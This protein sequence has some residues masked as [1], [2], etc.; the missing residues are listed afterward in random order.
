MMNDELSK[1]KAKVQAEETKHN[2]ER[3]V[4]N[5]LHLYFF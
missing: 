4:L 5:P 3:F 1:V 2:F